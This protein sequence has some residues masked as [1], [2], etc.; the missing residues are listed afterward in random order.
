M[1]W[2]NAYEISLQLSRV[3][4]LKKLSNPD[5]V[6]ALPIS[7]TLPP[8]HMAPTSTISNFSGIDFASMN[9][10]HLNFS[11]HIFMERSYDNHNQWILY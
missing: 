4:E 11:M 7:A 6:A 5:H 8:P 10:N 2:L 9:L 1:H 3:R